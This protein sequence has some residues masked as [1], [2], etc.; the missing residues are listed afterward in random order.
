MVLGLGQITGV[1]M[2]GL[3]IL[4][5]IIIFVCWKIKKNKARI[6]INQIENSSTVD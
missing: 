4:F 3:I 2:G 1:I 5:L 6:D